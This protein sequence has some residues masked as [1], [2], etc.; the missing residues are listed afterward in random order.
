MGIVVNMKELKPVEV[1]VEEVGLTDIFHPDFV[2]AIQKNLPGIK[3]QHVCFFTLTDDSE[4]GKVK[5][6]LWIG[7]DRP[8][9]EK[10]RVLNLS[11]ENSESLEA[12]I[13]TLR[14]FFS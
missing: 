12:M 8:K 6:K 1:R 2:K 11:A 5:E 9:D 7:H 3:F 4:D 14:K 10:N 13:E